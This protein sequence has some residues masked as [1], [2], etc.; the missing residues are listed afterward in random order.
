MSEES[1]HP[2]QERIDFESEL[3]RHGRADPFV[4]FEVVFTSGDRVLVKSSDYLAFAGNTL[5]IIYKN[6]VRTYRKNQIVGFH[7][8]D[9]NN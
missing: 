9:R 5:V 6:G 8:Q 2:E 1:E 7:V 3:R 4:P